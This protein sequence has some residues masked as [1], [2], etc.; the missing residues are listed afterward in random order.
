MNAFSWK[1]VYSV[2]D[3]ELDHQ[4][5]S[6]IAL[7]NEYYSCQLN[8]EHERAREVLRSLLALTVRHFQE[9]ETR[10]IR[11][12]YPHL[13]QHQRAHQE[14]LKSVDGLVKEYLHAPNSETAGRLSTFLKVWLT[15]HILGSDK[16]YGPYLGRSAPGHDHP[17][18]P[19]ASSASP[20]SPAAP[21][22]P[23]PRAA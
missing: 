13:K 22:S 7:M 15:R 12:G 20:A 23:A 14:L 11:A 2:G 9:E 1:P 16:Q 18:S 5:Q 4:H 6:L 19:D 17:A 21:A 8:G 10:M 3:D